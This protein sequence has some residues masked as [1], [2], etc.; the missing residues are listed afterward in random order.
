MVAAILILARHCATTVVTDRVGA[1]TTDTTFA[2]IIQATLTAAGTHLLV[3]VVV[4]LVILVA[5][6]VVRIAVRVGGWIA[7][8]VVIVIIVAPT[9]EGSNPLSNVLIAVRKLRSDF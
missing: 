8:L 9:P 2:A 6:K 3:A 4:V 5:I 7:V 1:F